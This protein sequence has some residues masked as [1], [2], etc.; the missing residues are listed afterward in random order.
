MYSAAQAAAAAAA[1]AAAMAARHHHI[2]GLLSHSEEDER[3]GKT[4]YWTEMEHNQFL[5][6]VKLFGP[7]NYVAIS[8]FVGTR[9][10]KQ[11][12]THA[13]KYQM[14]LEREAR[15]RRAVSS[16]VM[17]GGGPAGAGLGVSSP[18]A[19]AAAAAAMT[20]PPQ[21][22]S[23]V[24]VMN[25]GFGDDGLRAA[26]DNMFMSNPACST[27]SL[28]DIECT[29]Q[30]LRK[31][32]T[33]ASTALD[34]PC[35]VIDDEE[36]SM[37]FLQDTASSPVST[38]GFEDADMPIADVCDD[39]LIGGVPEPASLGAAFR[40]NASLT[41]L[42]DYD[43]FMRK[44][45]AAVHDRVDNLGVYDAAAHLI[46]VDNITAPA[47]TEQFEDSLLMDL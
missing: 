27:D 33:D 31:A 41:N 40:K 12:R 10:P 13:Q 24:S 46:E 18:A 44:I 2:G 22:L 28:S 26:K 3:A 15:K 47:K 37:D 7:K 17:V 23:P 4:R 34:V 5:Y 19:A 35:P 16:V 36:T 45:T 8:Q 43:D 11:V 42:A 1:A 14:K 25:T 9:T 30:D 32:S 29:E 21:I 6:A 38:D 39:V 20:S